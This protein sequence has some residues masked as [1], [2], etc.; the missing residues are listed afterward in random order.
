MTNI[1]YNLV[2]NSKN[3]TGWMA[4]SIDTITDAKAYKIVANFVWP[5]VDTHTVLLSLST[6]INSS[7]I[8]AIGAIIREYCESVFEQV[9]EHCGKWRYEE[10]SQKLSCIITIAGSFQIKYNRAVGELLELQELE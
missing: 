2:L 8:N 7:G 3:E 9:L 5:D 1:F 4:E 10:A 6:Y